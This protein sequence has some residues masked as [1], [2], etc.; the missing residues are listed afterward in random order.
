M[1]RWQA[2]GARGERHAVGS[3]SLLCGEGGKE[4]TAHQRAAM[5]Q[6]P[7]G[8]VCGAGPPATE[9]GRACALEGGQRCVQRE[10]GRIAG[11]AGPTAVLSG[12]RARDMSLSCDLEL[13]GGGGSRNW[14][15]GDCSRRG[16]CPEKVWCPESAW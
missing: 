13:G 11:H 7:L 5:L 3:G 10:E 12:G 4:P 14:G 2:P 8:A 16:S 15:A 1:E 9:T 6:A